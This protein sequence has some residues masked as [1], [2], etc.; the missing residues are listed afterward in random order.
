MARPE[1]EPA[2]GG[3]CAPG[4]F[5]GGRGLARSMH[6][7]H[8]RRLAMEESPGIGKSGRRRFPPRCFALGLGALAAL[9]VG[10]HGEPAEQG[11][12][13]ILF[14]CDAVCTQAL[15]SSNAGPLRPLQYQD[16]TPIY[17]ASADRL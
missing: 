8:L 3:P 13:E 9:T 17:W 10:R 1:E 4:A 2:G 14:A 12:A 5:C 6:L 16:G 11:L 15:F 7:R